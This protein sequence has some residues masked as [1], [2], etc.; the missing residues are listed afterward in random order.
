T[1][2]SGC[3]RAARSSSPTAFRRSSRRR[4]R[5]PTASCSTASCSPGMHGRCARCL[6]RRCSAGSAGCGSGRSCCAKR[7]A[8]LVFDLLEDAGVDLRGAPLRTRRARLEAIVPPA[9]SPA[10]R[11]SPRIEASGWDA[12]ARLRADS[13]GR[14]VEGMMLKRAQ[15]AYGVG[16]TKST[17][18]GDWWKWKIDPLSVD[19]VLVHAQPGHGRRAS[20]YTDYTFAVWSGPAGDSARSLVPFAKAYS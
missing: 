1:A 17:A 5:C 13:R 2:K 14:G 9:G 11:P 15:S 10:L 16:R 4:T 8:L 3:G 12:L 7:V 19:C 6:S 20:L 18:V